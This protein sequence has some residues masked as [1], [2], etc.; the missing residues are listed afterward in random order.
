MIHTF[1]FFSSSATPHKTRLKDLD[2][3][4]KKVVEIYNN[5]GV[6]ELGRRDATALIADYRVLI[7]FKNSRRARAFT[8]LIRRDGL[9]WSLYV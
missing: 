3:F 5:D 2:K 6:K 9:G 1:H 4:V 8:P 7:F